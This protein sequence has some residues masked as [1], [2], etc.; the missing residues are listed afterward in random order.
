MS[1]YAPNPKKQSIYEGLAQKKLSELTA[2]E[3][4]LFTD[5]TF[6]QAENQDALFTYNLI[7]KAAMR[8]GNAMP[9]KGHMTFQQQTAND[10]PIVIRP[11]KGEVWNVNAIAVTNLAALS[12][13]Q[14]YYVFISTDDDGSVP[15]TSTDLF[16]ASLSSTATALTT[17]SFF[18]DNAFLPIEITNTMFLRVYG[19]FTGTSAGHVINWFYAYTQSR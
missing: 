3:I 1:N 2:E 7:N 10:V 9:D 16:Y 8:D 6:V 18:D 13:S 19:N 15:Q 14:S 11:P 12:A 5:P 4:E 17:E